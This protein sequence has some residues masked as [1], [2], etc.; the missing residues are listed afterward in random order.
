MTIWLK[1][2]TNLLLSEL[3]KNSWVKNLDFVSLII[4]TISGFQPYWH[5]V[6]QC[7]KCKFL[8]KADDCFHHMYAIVAAAVGRTKNSLRVNLIC[9]IDSSSFTDSLESERGRHKL[10]VLQL[11]C[12]TSSFM[13]HSD[14]SASLITSMQ[15]ACLYRC[16]QGIDASVL[17]HLLHA[18][19]RPHSFNSRTE[20]P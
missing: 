9:S 18:G 20:I 3:A 4:S 11:R 2:L 1:H 5:H 16:L 13:D 8:Q 12:M 19:Y 6:L 17:T 15:Q 14:L 7:I 10:L